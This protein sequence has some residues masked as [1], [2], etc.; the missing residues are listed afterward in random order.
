M[1]QTHGSG[2]QE[3]RQVGAGR[4]AQGGRCRVGAG[5]EEGGGCREGGS[6]AGGAGRE[7]Q[8][9]RIRPPEKAA[10]LKGV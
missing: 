8:G 6:R 5:R 7:V 10:L 1:R 9:Y 2:L 4:E 3:E